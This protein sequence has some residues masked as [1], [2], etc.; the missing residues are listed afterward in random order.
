[1]FHIKECVVVYAVLEIK[2][3][4]SDRF[5]I[6]PNLCSFFKYEIRN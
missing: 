6:T 3:V 4:V 2:H 1:M 5:T